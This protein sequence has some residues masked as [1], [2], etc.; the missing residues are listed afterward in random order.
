MGIVP[1]T[2]I[3]GDFMKIPPLLDQATSHHG[4]ILPEEILGIH[5]N[6][7]VES[8]LKIPHRDAKTLC[9]TINHK[10]LIMS[11]FHDITTIPV[12]DLVPLPVKKTIGACASSHHNQLPFGRRY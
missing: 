6:S 8:D 1:K 12:N 11:N 9:Y 10:A 4:P 3:I 2:E 7:F 5:A